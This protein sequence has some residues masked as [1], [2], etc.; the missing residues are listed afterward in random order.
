[1]RF[2]ALMGLLAIGLIP[3]VAHGARGEVVYCKSGCDYFI[4]ETD[5]GFDLLERYGGNEPSD[6]DVLVGDFESYGTKDIYN[7]SVDAEVRVWVEDLWM[8]HDAAFEALY[9]KCN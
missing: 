7:L 2:G 4:V 5:A 3:G 9:E 1:M 8:S 6:G